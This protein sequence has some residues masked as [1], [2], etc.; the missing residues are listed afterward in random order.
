MRVNR[1]ERRK[2]KWEQKREYVIDKQRE[3]NSLS[4]LVKETKRVLMGL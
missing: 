3:F 2:R 1:L 4:Q